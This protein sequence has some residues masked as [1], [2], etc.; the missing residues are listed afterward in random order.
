M[1]A[2]FKEMRGL[3]FDPTF[4]ISIFDNIDIDFELNMKFL[5]YYIYLVVFLFQESA[6]NYKISNVN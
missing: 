6:L 5:H 3:D 4:K 1:L 2:R